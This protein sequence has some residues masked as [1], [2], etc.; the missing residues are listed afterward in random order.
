MFSTIIIQNNKSCNIALEGDLELFKALRLRLSYKA[1]GVEYTQAFKNG[2]DGVSYLLDKKGNF[3]SGLLSI[4]QTFLKENNVSF[5][6]IDKRPSV[7]LEKEIDISKRL[8]KMGKKPRDYQLAIAEAATKH[9]K[10]II[11]AA[12]GSGKSISAAL[13]TAKLN[14]PTIIYVVGL[15]LLEQFHTLFTDIFD[16]PIGFIGNG[17]CDI[18]KINIASVWTIGKA[19]DLKFKMFDDEDLSEKEKFNIDNKIKIQE[20]LKQTD[21]HIFDECHMVACDTIKEI[22]K[23]INPFRSFGMSGTPFRD[24]GTDL[25]INGMLGEQIINVSASDLIKRKILAQPIIKFINVPPLSVH[26]RTY[27]DVY[28]EYVVENEARNFLILKET[29][30]LVDKGYQVLVLFKQIKHG[31]ILHS[32]FEKNGMEF[33]MLHGAHSLGK[34]TEIKERLLNK[35]LNVVLASTIFDLGVDISTLSGLVLAGG[36]KSSV[37]ALQRIGRVVRMAPGKSVAAIVDFVDNVRFLKNHSDIRYRIYS[38]ENGFEVKWV[39]QNYG[40]NNK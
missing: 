35:K 29:Q 30:K 15:D 14:K 21:V 5:N 11:R 34:R 1:V 19:L 4:V 26:G 16:E 25:L 9:E 23:Q 40:K 6:I 10:G 8:E 27:H 31:K 32:L 12:T 37:K 28:G 17:V 36:G 2:W 38:A 7:A 24:D 3:P 20:L 13:M 33:E 18:K 39:K 22:F